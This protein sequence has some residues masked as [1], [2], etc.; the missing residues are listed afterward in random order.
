VSCQKNYDVSEQSTALNSQIGVVPVDVATNIAT[1]FFKVYYENVD[2][3][4]IDSQITADENG[5]PLFY[6]FNYKNGGFLIVSAEYGDMPI[7]ANDVKNVF[8]AKGETINAGLGMWMID[9]RE[10]IKGIRAGRVKPSEVASAMW[11]DF[12]N[13]TF[14]ATFKY[15]SIDDIR[16]NGNKAESRDVREL[17]NSGSG[18]NCGAYSWN[19]SQVGP[20]MTTKWGQGCGY[21]DLTPIM[22]YNNYCSH[23]PTGCVAT[24]M[25]QIVKFSH[26]SNMNY[27]FNNMLDNSGTPATSKLMYDCGRAVF[28]SYG[29]KSSNADTY[30]VE[31]WLEFRGYSTD[32]AFGDYDANTHLL[33]LSVGMPVLLGGYTGE[34]CFLWWCWGS[35]D[36]HEWV[37]DGYQMALHRCYGAKIDFW[38]N[39]GWDSRANGFYYNPITVGLTTNYNFSYR[40]D[41]V[42]NIHP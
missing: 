16:R 14:K 42:Y 8:P 1:N 41:M 36:G 7:L 22:V 35:G 40:R 4:P 10:R 20:F 21:N 37:S 38:M 23:A 9:T 26:P 24:A 19:N 6:L 33:N 12:K 18:T 3:K 29:Y 17:P 15:T 28:T 13:G 5:V 2:N 39:W 34:S 25:A 32:A 30:N 27:D 11:N 31:N